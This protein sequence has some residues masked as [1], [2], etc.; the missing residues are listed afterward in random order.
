MTETLGLVDNAFLQALTY[1]VPVSGVLISF[2]IVRYPD[3]TP[4]G[5]FLLGA[6]SFAAF[7]TAGV[8]W[9]IAFI[10]S[11]FAGALAGAITASLNSVLGISRLLTG[12][13]TT[14]AVYSLSFRLLKGS[15]NAGISQIHTTFA[16]AKFADGMG[17]LA[18]ISVH[19]WEILLTFSVAAV[20]TGIAALILHSEIGLFIRAN[21]DNPLRLSD[22]GRRSAVYTM[23]GLA[24]ANG[25]I[26]AGGA[27]SVARQG[28]VDIGTGF[29]IIVALIAALV[30]GEQIVKRLPF[31]WTD[32]LSG[33]LFVPFLGAFIYYTLFLIV[34]RVSFAGI[35]PFSIAPTDLKLVS[36]AFVVLAIAVNRNRLRNGDEILPL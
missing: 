17:P 3:L 30:I 26:G 18:A 9:P 10:C 8:P 35:L 16:S 6:V 31:R 21:G 4:D 36:A 28:F 33:R 12:I 11:A 7:V 20:V 24:L 14:M 34:L 19:P 5:S 15:P 2:R 27:L 25:L 1:G 23:L 13:L 29:G 22:L 32:T